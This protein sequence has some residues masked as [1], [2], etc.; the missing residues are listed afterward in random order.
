LKTIIYISFLLFILT[1]RQVSSQISP[2]DLSQPHSHLEGI[3]NCTRCHEPG[4][5]V[6]SE[7]CLTCHTEIASRIRSNKGY[8]SSTDVKG[9]QCTECHNEH[10]GKKFRLIRLDTSEFNHNLTGYRLS[11]PHSLIECSECHNKKLIKDTSLKQKENTWLGAGT[12]CL[13][14]HAD[15]HLGTLPSSCLDCHGEDSFETAPGFS[16]DRARFRLT[17]KHTSV[18]CDKCHKTTLVNGSPYQEFRGIKFSSCVN[19]HS[20]P[21]NGKLGAD[22]RKCHTET[23]FSAIKSISGFDHNK[24][25]FPLEGRHTAVECKACHKKGLTASLSHA[26]CTD[27]H[28]DYHKGQFSGKP[29]LADCSACH[30]T[31]GFGSFTF[32][33]DQHNQSSFPLRGA[34]SALPCFECHRKQDSWSFRQIGADCRDCHVNIHKGFIDTKYYPGE[35]CKACHNE[36]AWNDV[37]FDH[38]RT[39][40]TLTGKHTGAECRDCH[41]KPGGTEYVLTF[42]GTSSACSS[43]HDDIHQGQFAEAACTGC[44]NTESWHPAGFDHNRTG[45]RLDGKHVGVACTECHKPQQKEGTKFIL[46]KIKD[47][48]CESCHY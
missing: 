45:F 26:K 13:D 29:E 33:I 36:T 22:C 39:T 38:T 5:K 11:A 30:S 23:S 37:L 27:C 12:E 8:H 6:T 15:H 42:T 10:H 48:R 46:Y 2:G 32:T 7:K 17:G 47:F 24:T 40:F 43:C 16:H 18:D 4:N 9:R 41:R 21:H 31:K 3:S 28:S 14:C 44:H 25:N 1:G 34:H 20:D 35:N 19:C